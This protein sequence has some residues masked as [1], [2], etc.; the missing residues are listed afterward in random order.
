[1]RVCKIL[2]R[3]YQDMVLQPIQEVIE[4]FIWR[5]WGMGYLCVSGKLG[6]QETLLNPSASPELFSNA[7][8]HD[9]HLFMNQ[10]FECNTDGIGNKVELPSAL[11]SLRDIFFDSVNG[12]LPLVNGVILFYFLKVKEA[13]QSSK[14][15][16][17]KIRKSFQDTDKF[18]I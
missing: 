18:R 7:Y 1:M 10:S 13:I 4:L 3:H 16:D 9:N 15:T 12:Y 8:C 14:I 5:M 11:F 2:Q 17:L 6:S